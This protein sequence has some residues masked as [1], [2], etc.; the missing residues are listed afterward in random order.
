MDEGEEPV[1]QGPDVNDGGKVE[2]SGCLYSFIDDIELGRT[3]PLASLY[4]AFGQ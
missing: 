1:Q 3:S 4:W 2:Q